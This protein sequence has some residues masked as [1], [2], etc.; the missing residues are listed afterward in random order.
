MKNAKKKVEMQTQLV[1]LIINLEMLLE[2]II[3]KEEY[4]AIKCHNTPG[5]NDRESYEINFPYVGGGSLEE[6]FV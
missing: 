1:S 4:I 3:K 5:D 6:W 2:T